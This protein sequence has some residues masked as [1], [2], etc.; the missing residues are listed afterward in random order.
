MN[1]E[2]QQDRKHRVLVVDRHVLVGQAISALFRASGEVSSMATVARHA[3]RFAENFMPHVAVVDVAAALPA[4]GAGMSTATE[5]PPTGETLAEENSTDESTE[6]D[7]ATD[8]TSSRRQPGTIADAFA[9]AAEIMRCSPQ[10]RVLFVDEEIHPLRVHRSLHAGGAGYWTKHAPFDQ[11]F[12]AVRRIARGQWCFCPDV[13]EHLVLTDGRW[14]IRP[15]CRLA[16]AKLTK[17]EAQMMSLL[18]EGLSVRQCAEQMGISPN[19]ADN[20]KSNLMRKLD[21]HKMSELVRLAL[22]QGMTD[23]G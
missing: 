17:R 7:T 11:I 16:A 23:E 4:V 18:V 3:P 22:C 1:E 14:R 21:V 15:C 6:D 13:R 20:H 5:Q 2:L 12:Q 19:T 9:T 10:T 8:G